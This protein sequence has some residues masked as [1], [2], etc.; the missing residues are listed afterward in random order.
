MTPTIRGQ[1]EQ[2]LGWGE[3]FGGEHYV[4]N[5]KG[6]SAEVLGGPEQGLVKWGPFTFK[7]RSG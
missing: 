2:K 3:F 1:N 5:K 7:A 6:K 4:T